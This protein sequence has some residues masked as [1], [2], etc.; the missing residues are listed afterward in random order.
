MEAVERKDLNDSI[1]H[2]AECGVKF[3]IG[4]MVIPFATRAVELTAERDDG[5]LGSRYDDIMAVMRARHEICPPKP[6]PCKHSRCPNCQDMVLFDHDNGHYV[7]CQCFT[8]LP[9]ESLKEAS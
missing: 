9:V 7:C 3:K 5:H 1:D 6:C 4:D 2:C 8:V